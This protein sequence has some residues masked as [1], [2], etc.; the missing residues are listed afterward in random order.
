MPGIQTQAQGELL[1]KLED[2]HLKWVKSRNHVN[3]LKLCIDMKIVPKGL[4]FEY[5]VKS[6]HL[7]EGNMEN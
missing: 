3:Y 1:S 7:F 2:L 6:K 4:N 5:L